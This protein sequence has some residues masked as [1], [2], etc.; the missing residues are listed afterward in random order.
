MGTLW[1]RVIRCRGRAAAFVLVFDAMLVDGH[2]VARG[3]DV[4][5]R[6][7]GDEEKIRALAAI[8]THGC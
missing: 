4:L 3:Q 1:I 2:D 6:I 7:A 8:L 5:I